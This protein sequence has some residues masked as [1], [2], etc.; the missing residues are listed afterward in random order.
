MSF[1]EYKNGKRV[2][3]N[4]DFEAK[5][6]EVVEEVKEETAPE[7]KSV[8]VYP[9]KDEPK[10][11]AIPQL[12]KTT[13][14]LTN[15]RKAPSLNSDVVTTVA[16]GAEFKVDSAKSTDDFVAVS[17]QGD[18]AFIKRDLVTIYDNPAYKSNEVSKIG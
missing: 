7:E 12:C 17:V 5:T 11:K 6:E 13:P 15:V 2:D 9:K 3:R 16:K 4:E 1:K 18:I 10:K 8:P 14:D